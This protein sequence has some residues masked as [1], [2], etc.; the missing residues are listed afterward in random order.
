MIITRIS[1]GLG[2]QMFEYAAARALALRHGT[3]LKLDLTYLLD[4]T[5]R[6]KRFKIT[7]REYDLD[8]FVLSCSFLKKNETPLWFLGKFGFI[9]DMCYRKVFKPH[10]TE[11]HFQYDPAF[12]SFPDNTYLDGVWQSPKYF[13][14]YEDVIRKDFSFKNEMAEEVKAL[15]AEIR[16]KESVCVHVRRSDF[17]GSAHDICDAKY[18][19]RGIVEIAERTAIDQI[20]VFSDDIEWCK[21]NVSLGYP[22]VFVS[23]EFAGYKNT[24]HLYLMGKCRYFVIANSSYSWWAAWLSDYAKKIVVAPKRWF[25]DSSIDASDVTPPEWIRV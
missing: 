16:N 6:P 8:V 18:Y 20:Y 5:P 15:G 11:R 7:F 3:E 19:A 22:T 12:L 4:R 2:N 23:N 14:G 9:V 21:K 1:G 24:G 17:L 13:A 25:A 10:G